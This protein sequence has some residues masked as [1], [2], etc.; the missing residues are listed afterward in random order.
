MIIVK[1]ILSLLCAALVVY[2]ISHTQNQPA[3]ENLL[4]HNRPKRAVLPD[5]GTALYTIHRSRGLQ[6]VE[7]KGGFFDLDLCVYFS[8]DRKSVLD[9]G[10]D[11]SGIKSGGKNSFREQPFRSFAEYE[12]FKK[13]HQLVTQIIAKEN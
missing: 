5:S 9:L 8:K 6:L 10:Y 3:A 1:I 11:I 4:F 7:W 2:R 13:E 12:R